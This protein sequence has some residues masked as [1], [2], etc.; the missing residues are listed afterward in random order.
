MTKLEGK[1][2]MLGYRIEGPHCGNCVSFES[3]GE[4]AEE[5]RK[6]CSLGGFAVKKLAWCTKHEWRKA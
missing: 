3:V 6:R 5:R 2:A 1:K 4:S